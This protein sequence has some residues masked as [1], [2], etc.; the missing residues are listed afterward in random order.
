MAKEMPLERMVP[1]AETELLVQGKSSGVEPF[2]QAIL[3][4]SPTREGEVM[5]VSAV[6]VSADDGYD[7]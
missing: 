3:P 6:D 1:S 5:V 4:S 7:D 2:E